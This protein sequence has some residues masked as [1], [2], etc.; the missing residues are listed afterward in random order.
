MRIIG[1]TG[2]IG[3]GKSTVAGM[4]HELGAVVVDADEGAR[5]VVAPGEPALLEIVEAFGPGML[6]PDHSLDRERLAARVFDDEASRVRLNEITHPRVRAWMAERM[7]AA[8]EAGAEVIVL[9]IPLLFES[10]LETGLDAIVVVWTPVEV[11]FRRAVDRGMAGADVRAR[12]KAQM[13]I[14]EKRARATEVVDNSGTREETLRQV[15]EL[16]PRLLGQQP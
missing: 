2:G 12:I 1:L 9:D 14:D 10:G 3:S 6:R 13:P 5:A 4:L 7:R 11:Q 8:A 16:W 15:R